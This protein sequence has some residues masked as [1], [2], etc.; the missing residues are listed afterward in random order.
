MQI[1]AYILAIVY[2]I[3]II[4]SLIVGLINGTVELAFKLYPFKT[5]LALVI[6]IAML[7][8]IVYDTNC[9]STGDCHI[10]TWVRLVL[11]S[12]LPILSIIMIFVSLFS[13]KLSNEIKN[14]VQNAK[15][16]AYAYTH[17]ESIRHS[18]YA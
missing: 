16:F 2:F 15:K 11:Y 6:Y 13:D 7:S 1:Q 17:P 3:L 9:L 5:L 12:I 10:W 8:L 14:H 18:Y 4:V